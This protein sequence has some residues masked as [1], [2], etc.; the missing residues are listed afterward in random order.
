MRASRL[1]LLLLLLSAFAA[2]PAP[3]QQQAQQRQGAPLLPPSGMMPPPAAAQPILPAEALLPDTSPT[4][5][6]GTTTEAEGG[7]V[8]VAPL[9][10]LDRRPGPATAVFGASLFVARPTAPADT[11]NPNYVIGAGDRVSVSVW[12][13]V[14]AQVLAVVD[15]E[16]NIFLPSIGPVRLGGVRA[17]DVQQV[18]EQQVRRIYTQQVQVYAVLLTPG[19]VGVFVTGFVRMPGRHQGS[20]GD[21]VLDYLARA[22]GV[23][24]SRGS[25]RD[26]AILRG[27]RTIARVD[28]YDFLL[29]GRL[30][31][32]QFQEGDTIIV[33]RQRRLV[34]ADGAVRNNFLFEV[35]AGGTTLSGAALMDLA[36]PLPSATNVVVRGSRNGRPW[37]RY[38]T[39]EELRRLTLQDQDVVSFIS[40]APAPTIRVSIEGSRIGPSVLIADRDIGLCD[41]LNHVEVDP[42]LADPASVFLLRPGL[43]AQQRRAI[44]EALDR[45]ERQL[46]LSM[47][48]TRSVG[49]VRAREAELISTYIQR[50]RRIQPEG[51]LVVSDGSG[52][53]QDVR[54]V[55]GDVIVI[56]ERA[57]TVLVAGE[58]VSPQPVVARPGMTIEDFIG[59]AGGRSQR[60]E[61]G[62]V[63]IRR[64]SGQVILDPQEPPRGGDELIVLPYLDPLAFQ[65]AADILNLVFQSAISVRTLLR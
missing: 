16:G 63:M 20:G 50:G 49:E 10:E 17:G 23:D 22:G 43:A 38:A 3:A 32:I 8:L 12:G 34:G 4:A 42:A 11:P 36:A 13:A 53:C 58:V 41:L 56:P 19:R 35:P 6:V 61:R 65:I 28:L 2:A 14:E 54:L 60:G 46:F 40:D 29:R 59:R 37:S 31:R 64:A 62:Q 1:P 18:V 33:A 25:Y 45:L 44:N 48:A 52:R 15:P 7:P 55:D 27:D 47:S 51:R 30:P 9:G 39:L 57:D 21:S 26:I 24:P 5:R